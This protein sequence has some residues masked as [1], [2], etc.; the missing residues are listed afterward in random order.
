[1]AW[2]TCLNTLAFGQPLRTENADQINALSA[3]LNTLAF[4]QPLRT[5]RSGRHRKGGPRVSIPSHS[6]SLFGQSRKRQISWENSVSIPSHSGSLFG[7]IQKEGRGKR[8]SGLNTLNTL[9]FGQPLR[10]TS[11][12][13]RSSASPRV[14]IPSHSG[15]LFGHEEVHEEGRRQFQSQYPRIR[16]A[17]SDTGP[18][19]RSGRIAKS[20]YPRIRAASS[21]KEG[22]DG[23]FR[24]RGSQYPR[25]RAASSDATI[26][27]L[28]RPP[29]MR[30]NT[31]AFGQPLRTWG[32]VWAGFSPL[33]SQYPRIEGRT[34]QLTCY[35][36]A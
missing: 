21:D 32:R 9:A 3:S 11:M 19:R 28:C 8:L 4:G 33:K 1:M 10:T 15:S 35:A 18:H 6:G 34:S 22:N 23:T 20:Q 14:S 27:M 2:A 25:I 7:P 13:T 30:L 29:A 36:Q 5:R 16:A 26:G 12:T 17:S 24:S 31:L